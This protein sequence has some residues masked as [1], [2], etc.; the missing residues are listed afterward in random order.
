MLINIW[1]KTLSALDKGA[2]AAAIL[3]VDFENV[4]NRMD[5]GHCVLKVLELCGFGRPC[6]NGPAFLKDRQIR[7]KIGEYLTTKQNI[8]VGSPQGSVLGC[9]LSCLVE[10]GTAVGIIV[11]IA[12]KY[13]DDTTLVVFVKHVNAILHLSM[14]KTVQ[15]LNPKLL[16][17]ALSNLK[18]EAEKNGMQINSSKAQ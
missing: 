9:L 12:F 11:G 10:I 17:P 3:G 1:D 18:A 4:F 2:D 7:I 6:K 5:H 13:V 15:K 16:E 8:M 14:N